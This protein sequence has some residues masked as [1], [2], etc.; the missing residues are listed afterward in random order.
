MLDKETGLSAAV[1]R[2]PAYGILVSLG[3]YDEGYEFK[4]DSSD[5]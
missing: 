3:T 4:Q 2:G 5:R 1:V